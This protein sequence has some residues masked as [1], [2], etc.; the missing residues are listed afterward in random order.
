MEILFRRGTPGSLCGYASLELLS[1]ILPED[2]LVLPLAARFPAALAEQPSA[3]QQR[4]PV[5]LM[6]SSRWGR[7]PPRSKPSC[8]A[9]AVPHPSLLSLLT[10]WG[11]ADGRHN[12]QAMPAVA[13]D[14]ASSQLDLFGRDRDREDADAQGATIH[15]YIREVLRLR[16]EAELSQGVMVVIA[17]FHANALRRSSRGVAY[18]HWT[19][20]ADA[21]EWPR[22]GSATDQR[23]ASDEPGWRN[24]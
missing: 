23:A 12:P 18:P 8:L 10:A 7:T 21:R 13:I 6:R 20:R 2:H 17:D 15:A 9:G 4:P 5:T 24:S 16:W 3:T 14:Q 22:G 1:R 11:V 19:H